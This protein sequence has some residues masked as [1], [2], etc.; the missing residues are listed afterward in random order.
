MKKTIL[1]TVTVAALVAS[2]PFAKANAYLELISGSSALGFSVGGNNMVFSG[3][4]GSWDFAFSSG[5]SSGST[6][7][8]VGLN[9][10]ANGDA[11]TRGLTVVYSSGA[12]P[13]Y[14]NWYFSESET[15]DTLLA[16][17]DV[18]RSGS[19]WTGAGGFGTLLGSLSLPAT[20]TT[21]SSV[22]VSGVITTP[23]YYVNE[24]I[25][26]AGGSTT[27]FAATAP[28]VNVTASFLVSAVPDGGLTLA[29][30]GL[31]FVGMATI[32]ARMAKRA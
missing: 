14:G 13:V 31:G 12:Y 10:Q 24:V 28:S 11:V 26:I 3:S 30:L 20:P 1:A 16:S 8:N 32:R 5:T 21:Q 15:H 19:L 9:T 6:M 4:V 25:N 29:M 27:T 7:L 23:P 17:A 22:G 18:Y 2:A